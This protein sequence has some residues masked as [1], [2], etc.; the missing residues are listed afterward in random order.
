[1]ANRDE[2]FLQR[3]SRRKVEARDGSSPTPEAQDEAPPT[4]D[5]VAPAAEPERQLTEDDFADVD[6][7][8][9]DMQSDY[10]RFM[11]KGVPEAIRQKA[12]RQL[13]SSDPVFS[14]IEPF[15]EYGGDFTDKAVAVA[16]GTLQT[17]WRIG[18]GF[19]TDEEAAEWDALGKP[20]VPKEEPV[21]ERIAEAE[22]VPRDA[23]ASVSNDLP[24]EPTAIASVSPAPEAPT[25]AAPEEAE[26]QGTAPNT[27][28]A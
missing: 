24:A 12:L 28:R 25:D 1:M 11:Q 27:P 16:P 6:F 2:P 10:A 4:A 21:S 19:L 5:A 9:L 15:N 7:A 26:D 22:A 14:A 13:W 18:K 17:A 3:W 23:T 8:A 20:A